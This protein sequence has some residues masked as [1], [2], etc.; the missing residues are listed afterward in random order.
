VSRGCCWAARA[1]ARRLGLKCG[2]SWQRGGLPAAA[3]WHRPRPASVCWQCW[4]TLGCR[5]HS[6]SAPARP[7]RRGRPGSRCPC[8]EEAAAAGGGRVRVAL[9]TAWASE[10]SATAG[11]RGSSPHCLHVLND[12]HVLHVWRGACCAHHHHAACRACIAAHAISSARQRRG[13]SHSA[14]SSLRGAGASIKDGHS[15]QWSARMKAGPCA[16]NAGTTDEMRESLARAATLP[17][18]ACK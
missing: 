3:A 1:S 18:C 12:A 8:Q 16:E 9:S 7:A 6:R 13:S 2:L 17:G 4:H 14:R 15:T 10:T 5:R 11:C